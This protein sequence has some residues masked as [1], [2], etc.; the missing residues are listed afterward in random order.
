MVVILA[1][2]WSGIVAAQ[3]YP[4]KPIRWVV[5][6]TPAGAFDAIARMAAEK[7]S[8]NLGQQVIVENRPGAGGAIGLD[9]VA[10]AAPDGYTIAIGGLPTHGINPSLFRKLPYD[11][12]RDFSPIS[13]LGMAGVVLIVNPSAPMKTV[14][15]FIAHAKANPGKL[16]YGSS[17]AGMHLSMEML[18]S[19][20]GIS[21]VQVPYKGSAPALV[22]LIA[23][24]IPVSIDSIPA[25]LQF[26]RSG[27]VRALAVGSAKR[28][29]VLPDVPTFIESGIAVESTLW[30]ALFAPAGLPGPVVEAGGVRSVA[31]GQSGCTRAKSLSLVG[32]GRTLAG[33]ARPGR[34]V[35]HR[36]NDHRIA[37][38]PPGRA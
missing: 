2:A 20:S 24:Q 6:Y 17:G 25:S 3:S 14:A 19:V 15:E 34:A 12:I 37:Q 13:M 5:P 26:I 8:L 31:H 29:R 4:N 16:S 18:R 22:D 35:F 32:S 36:R 38:R 21:L 28:S 27:R 7:M 33:G 1:C 11:H 9:A 30:Y 10:K 23:G